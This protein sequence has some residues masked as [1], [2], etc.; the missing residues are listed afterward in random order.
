MLNDAPVTRPASRYPRA[1]LAG[2]LVL[3]DEVLAPG[4]L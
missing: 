2:R 4:T 1:E 3:R